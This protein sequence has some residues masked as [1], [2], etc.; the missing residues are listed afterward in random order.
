[1]TALITNKILPCG[2][3]CRA[4]KISRVD[5]Q[6]V[7]KADCASFRYAPVSQYLPRG[8]HAQFVVHAPRNRKI[9]VIGMVQNGYV[10]KVRA[11]RYLNTDIIPDGPLPLSLRVAAPRSAHHSS[12]DTFVPGHPEE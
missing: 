7:S 8:A 1:M 10:A 11:S 3:Y 5:D 12:I 2:D 4:I 6:P 9:R